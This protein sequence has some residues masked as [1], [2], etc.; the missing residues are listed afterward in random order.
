[1]HP[2]SWVQVFNA[3][4][5]TVQQT[6]TCTEMFNHIFSISKPNQVTYIV[7]SSKELKECDL[8]QLA[9]YMTTTQ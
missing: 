9:A 1:M 3:F 4:S 8:Q 6:K 7:Y 2:Y 5:Y